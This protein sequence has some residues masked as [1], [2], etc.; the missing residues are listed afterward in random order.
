VTRQS[1]GHLYSYNE[2]PSG[3]RE[4]LGMYNERDASS[5][6]P[7]KRR[8]D[9]RSLATIAVLSLSILHFSRQERVLAME[10]YGGGRIEVHSVRVPITQGGSHA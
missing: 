1:F 8:K 5:R 3:I 4:A 9:E 10:R 2:I 7:A 6:D